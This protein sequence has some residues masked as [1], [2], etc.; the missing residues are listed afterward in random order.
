[1][2]FFSQAY[3]ATTNS[4]APATNDNFFSLIFFGGVLLFFYVLIWRPQSKRAKE[5]R[6]L[7]D[8]LAVGDEVSTA[9]GLVGKVTK[10][11]DNFL[12]VKIAADVEITLSK[13]AVTNTLPKGTLKSL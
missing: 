4:A 9:G 2:S 8:G 13:S 1:M 11:N 10:I 6:D 12:Q 7:L 3:A 5:Q